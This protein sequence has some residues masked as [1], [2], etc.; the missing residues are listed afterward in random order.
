M[1]LA[2]T[3]TY[4]KNFH[5]AAKNLKWYTAV[6]FCAEDKKQIRSSKRKC[7]TAADVHAYA[8]RFN[9]RVSREFHRPY[10][11]RARSTHTKWSWSLKSIWAWLRSK[12]FQL[13]QERGIISYKDKLIFDISKWE[14]E[15]DF[16]KMKRFPVPGVIIKA[17]QGYAADIMFRIYWSAAKLAGLFRGS[18]WYYDSRVSPKTQA[19]AWWSLVKSDPAELKYW[20]DFEENYGG[21]YKGLAN[22]KIFLEEFM[23][24][25]GLPAAQIGVYTGYYYWIDQTPISNM[26]WFGQFW[27]WEAWY[28]SDP[29]YV[30]IPPP[31]T[32]SKLVLWQFGTPNW[33]IQAGTSSIEIDASYFVRPGSEFSS[34]FG[35]NYTPTPVEHT[36][37]AIGVDEYIEVVN[38]VKCHV[39]LVDMT[40]KQIHL[41]HFNGGLGYV[42]QVKGAEVAFNGI[43]YDRAVES[44]LPYG[45]AYADGVAVNG[46]NPE[47]RYFLNFNRVN[48]VTFT[49]RNFTDFYNTTAFVRP[50]VINGAVAPDILNNPNKI[51]YTEIHA[52]A[53][54]G[55]C[56]DGRMIQIA[57]E[58]KVD[59]TTGKAY[60]G[61]TVPQLVNL[62]LKYDTLN[63]GQHGGGGDVGKTINGQIVNSFSDPQERAVAQVIYITGVKSMPPITRYEAIARADGTRVRP[64]HNTLNTYIA[65]W[66]QSSKF[67]G[68][69]LFTA[70]VATSYQWIGDVWLKLTHINDTPI[71]TLYPLISGPIWVAVKDKG[72]P[73]CDLHDYGDPTPV[74]TEDSMSFSV[75]ENGV[76]TTFSMTGKITK[77]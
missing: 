76:T 55:Y 51:E 48:A 20:A 56:Q 11:D 53:A 10:Q 63:A 15:V 71:T 31:W 22:L 24:L 8:V 7:K 49:Y 64:D 46:L 13:N 19:A 77:S 70:A 40:N 16:E 45:P 21:L 3:H 73:I 72:V 6:L 37:P 2:D 35:V 74:P 75:T 27:L 68:N 12:K 33:G 54:F 50:L 14:G 66:N 18:Y 61:I 4:E 57:A 30:L 60:Q 47:F 38:G 1:W 59:P 39:T 43:D 17:G 29:K 23:R 34:F 9:K 52:C 32:Q 41:K 25:S 28:I 26:S 42:S 36:Q 65:L 67:Q 44:K 62:L 58:G 69:E 5:P